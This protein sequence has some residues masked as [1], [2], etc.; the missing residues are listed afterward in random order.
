VRYVPP[1]EHIKGHLRVSEAR[2]GAI[3]VKATYEDMLRLIQA[4]L[5]G[6]DV[7][8]AW[9]LQ[10][11]EDVAQG[12]REGKIQ[13]AKQHFLD[14]GYFEGRAPYRI[15]VDEAWY[16]ATNADVAE[17]VR[18]GTFASGQAHFDAAG[19]QEGRLPRAP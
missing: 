10:Q 13:S 9:Y 19:Y 1:F 7:D 11:N 8:E 16:L 17:Q 5:V 3:R 6:I 4:L 15:A 18:L 2:G 14:H 12:I